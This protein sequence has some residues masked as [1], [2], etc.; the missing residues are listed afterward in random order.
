MSSVS[1]RRRCLSL[2]SASPRSGCAQVQRHCSSS[3]GVS[4]FFGR[5]PSSFVANIETL[6]QA[7]APPCSSG[8]DCGHPF[9]PFLPLLKLSC[10]WRYS[11]SLSCFNGPQMARTR[12]VA[13]EA[14][15]AVAE[16]VAASARHDAPR[17]PTCLASRTQEGF[18]NAP[19]SHG[20]TRKCEGMSK[21][22]IKRS[23]R[24]L[25]SQCNPSPILLEAFWY[26]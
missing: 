8:W 20:R 14:E 11:I 2:S 23:A 24:T 16:V 6:Q 13:L 12:G 7:S 21:A 9:P 18:A 22:A 15:E 3:W 26:F 19:S 25:R 5:P 10:S 17:I 1:Q 4:V